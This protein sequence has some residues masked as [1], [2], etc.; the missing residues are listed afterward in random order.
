MTEEFNLNERIKRAREIINNCENVKKSVSRSLWKDSDD[1][2]LYKKSKIE[3]KILLMCD[4]KFKELIKK[5]KEGLMIN[6][7][8]L[9]EFY[10]LIEGTSLPEEKVLEFTDEEIDK[11]ASNIEG[12]DLID[13]KELNH[14]KELRIKSVKNS[15]V[16]ADLFIEC[17]HFIDSNKISFLNKDDKELILK[18]DKYLYSFN[19]FNE[20]RKLLEEYNEDYSSHYTGE[21][22]KDMVEKNRKEIN[23]LVNLFF[24]LAEEE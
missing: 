11:I 17:F 3:L 12:K 4:K 10:K 19:Y 6:P 5:M 1:A 16:L 22:I 8:K 23:Q 9:D 20:L 18:F 24:K 13:E 7:D 21:N 14:L 15:I 2:K